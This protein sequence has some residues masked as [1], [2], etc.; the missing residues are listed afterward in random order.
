M[1][2]L[3]CQ[4]A[5]S[6]QWQRGPVRVTFEPKPDQKI[7]FAVRSRAVDLATEAENEDEE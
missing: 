3:R 5:P 1:H 4:P 6:P 7:V 2:R